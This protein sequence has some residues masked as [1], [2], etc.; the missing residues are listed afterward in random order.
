[1][2]HA[3]V[4]PFHGSCRSNACA[5]NVL[6]MRVFGTVPYDPCCAHLNDAMS[7]APSESCEESETSPNGA[8]GAVVPGSLDHSVRNKL[9]SLGIMQPYLCSHR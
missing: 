4:L 1:V 8:V 2:V 6:G 3:P 7:A 9:I 5:M